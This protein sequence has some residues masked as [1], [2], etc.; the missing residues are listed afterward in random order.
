[1]QSPN[2]TMHEDDKQFAMKPIVVF[3]A[4]L[5]F[6]SSFSFLFFLTNHVLKQ[7]FNIDSLDLRIQIIYR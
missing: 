6:V 1:M 2:A 5:I 7:R 3:A 4:H